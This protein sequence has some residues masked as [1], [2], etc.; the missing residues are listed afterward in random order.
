MSDEDNA[1]DDTVSQNSGHF[2][3]WTSAQFLSELG[4]LQPCL[5]VLHR[6][7]LICLK[8]NWTVMTRYAACTAS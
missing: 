4:P 2:P 5:L 3:S 6:K 8:K 7:R 1:D